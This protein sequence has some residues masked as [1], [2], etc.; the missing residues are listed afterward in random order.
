[1]DLPDIGQIRESI[2]IAKKKF[3]LLL[4]NVF[5]AF[6]NYNEEIIEAQVR[7]KLGP[8]IEEQIGSFR[9]EAKEAV[10]RAVTT[11]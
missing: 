10:K 3:T 5:N 11:W 4:R 8:E 2:S 9:Q 6:Y 1:M 7:E